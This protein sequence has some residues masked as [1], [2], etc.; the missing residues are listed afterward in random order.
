[1]LCVICCMLCASHCCVCDDMDFSFDSSTSNIITAAC[2]S[3]SAA[4]AVVVVVRNTYRTVLYTTM[5][6][7]DLLLG[8]TPKGYA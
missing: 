5:Q 4:A 2:S 1:M 3:E 7:A 6:D 8:I